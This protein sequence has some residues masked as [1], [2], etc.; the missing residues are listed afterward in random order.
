VSYNCFA[1]HHDGFAKKDFKM[2]GVI[3]LTRL[4]KLDYNYF[5][6]NMKKKIFSITLFIS[7][8]LVACIP[9]KKIFN[10]TE[11][12]DYEPESDMVVEPYGKTT[13]KESLDTY[14]RFIEILGGKYTDSSQYL[15]NFSEL[16]RFLADSQIINF[17]AREIAIAR[18]PEAAQEC[19][20]ENLIPP[21]GNWMKAASI[22]LIFEDVRR[23]I[24][25]PIW[26]TSWFRP[27]CYNRLVGGATNSDHISADAIDV[28]F[29]SESDF[30][31]AQ[32]YLCEVY[33]HPPDGSLIYAWDPLNM[34]IGLGGTAMHISLFSKKG[35]RYWYYPT[36]NDDDWA[37][38]CW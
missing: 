22:L 32:K 2:N 4:Q 8:M 26:V 11:P 18:T 17:T 24:N 25:A 35:R 19:G 1:K 31:I 38:G 33:W 15:T 36:Y 14:R 13:P 28:V 29:K 20:L 30:K 10:K 5:C 27:A 34:A 16:D 37:G 23:F 6:M 21:Q 12:I 9:E 7:L 3:S